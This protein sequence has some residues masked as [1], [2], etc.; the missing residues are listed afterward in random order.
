MAEASANP[1]IELDRVRVTPGLRSGQ[2]HLRDTRVTV[3]DILGWLAE[4]MTPEEILHDF[5]YLEAADI[6]AALA[7]AARQQR[8]TRAG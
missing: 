7:W 4:G 8:A 1:T 2:P 3:G 6:P 5:P